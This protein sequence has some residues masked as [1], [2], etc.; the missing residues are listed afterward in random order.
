MSLLLLKQ[1]EH[2]KFIFDT[3]RMLRLFC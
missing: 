3:I 2:K 1:L